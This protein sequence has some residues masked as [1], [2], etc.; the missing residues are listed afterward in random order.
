MDRISLALVGHALICV[1][2]PGLCRT[3]MA[4]MKRAG[5]RIINASFGCAR[6]HWHH[7]ALGRRDAGSLPVFAAFLLPSEAVLSSYR[8]PAMCIEKVLQSAG[9]PKSFLFKHLWSGHFSGLVDNGVS[10]CSPVVVT[11]K[12]KI[13]DFAPDLHGKACGVMSLFCGFYRWQL[14]SPLFGFFRFAPSFVERC[15]LLE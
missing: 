9:S 2:R 5:H 15:Q 12:P 11:Y 7:P 14:R 3:I 4:I 13:S 1:P 10:G 8:V 6:E